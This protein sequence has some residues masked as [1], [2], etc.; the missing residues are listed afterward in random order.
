MHCPYC[1]CSNGEDEHRCRRCGRRLQA[2]PSLVYP[3]ENSAAVRAPDPEAASPA[4]EPAPAEPRPAPRVAPRQAPLFGAA[5]R[6]NII[7]FETI[8]PERVSDRLR[9]QTRARRA[10]APRQPSARPEAAG[11]QNLFPPAA[12]TR[13]PAAPRQSAVPRTA[14]RDEAAIAPVAVR[15]QA[16]AADAGICAIGL[17]LAAVT[18]QVMGGR[19]AFARSTAL[20]WAGAAGAMVMFYHAFWSILG[21]ET[22]G[23]RGCGLRVLTF[24]GHPPAWKQ[25]VA[26]LLAG[27]LGIGALGLGVLWTLTDEETLAWHDHITKT[28]PT[29]VDATP[30]TFHRT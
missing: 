18:F 11:Q 15:L 10:A 19:F 28:F 8:A 27:C 6:P 3:V 7:P 5:E 26:R 24:D 12:A 20:F 23:M 29:L 14:V 17:A 13:Q 30:S 22:L 1:G 4:A 9:Q 25:R 16:A 21:R 2:L